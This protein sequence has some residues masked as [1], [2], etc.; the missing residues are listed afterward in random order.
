MNHGSTTSS[1]RI[2]D[3][4]KSRGFN[5]NYNYRPHSA[6]LQL[7]HAWLPLSQSQVG[8]YKIKIWNIFGFII[9]K[10]FV[11]KLLFSRIVAVTWKRLNTEMSQK[12]DS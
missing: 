12:T 3:R 8:F 2:Y 7:G 9:M 10:H 4:Q 1:C 5:V 6:G 11:L